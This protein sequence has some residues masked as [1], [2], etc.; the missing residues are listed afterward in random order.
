M[1]FDLLEKIKEVIIQPLLAFFLVLAIAYFFWGVF[2]FVGGAAEP[3]ARKTGRDHMIYGII[4]IFIM[5]S[6]IGILNFV[7]LTVGGQCP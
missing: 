7:C 6:V 2:E 1:Q 3:A 4:G 5:V